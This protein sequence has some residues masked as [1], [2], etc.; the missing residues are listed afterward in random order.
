[1][2]NKNPTG[3]PRNGRRAPNAQPAVSPEAASAQSAIPKTSTP[4]DKAAEAVSTQAA[5]PEIASPETA[6]PEAASTQPLPEAQGEPATD[7][8]AP[9]PDAPAFA[10]EAPAGDGGT[11]TTAQ[12]PEPEPDADTVL[13]D[14]PPVETVVRPQPPSPFVPILSGAAAGAIA[15]VAAAW[16][17]TT[18]VPA[19]GQGDAGAR[20][21]A[22]EQT[23]ARQAA[24]DA[25]R[26]DKVETTLRQ[27]VLPDLK[28]LNEGLAKANAD[29][30]ALRTQV[31]S[32]VDSAKAQAGDVNQRLAQTQK[33]LD[34]L[35]AASQASDRAAA[36]ITVAAILRDAVIAGRPFA[37]ELNAARALLGPSAGTLE[38][39]AAAASTGYAAPAALADRLAKDGAAAVAGTP[40]APPPA[41]QGLMGRLL[42]NAE[43]LV[44]VTP[45]GA[46]GEAQP[47][48][49]AILQKAVAAVRAGDLDG[50]LATLATLP[51][52][53]R[54]KLKPAITE[55]EGRRT[56]VATA[57]TMFQQALAAI[58]G[59]MP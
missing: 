54:E 32:G 40:G 36:A 33:Q 15:A 39:L 50:G 18:Y 8:A 22:L 20:I 11:D 51:A 13:R 37:T 44:R 21:A 23:L 12:K 6:R 31:Q 56:A 30:A 59:K 27:L 4:E 35:S 5:S 14:E 26:I 53:T 43:G 17:F 47:D 29:L 10:D 55:I 57:S 1:M 58:S 2:A 3:A 45:P 24:D 38:P 25:Q 28:P 46:S 41:G 19:P 34:A 16:M 49:D 7:P 42:S 48:Q 52:D 9:R